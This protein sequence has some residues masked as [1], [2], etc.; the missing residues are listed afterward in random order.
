MDFQF[1]ANAPWLDFIDTELGE[2]ATRVDLIGSF[3]DLLRWA[4][5]AG[6]L[7]PAERAALDK[8]PPAGRAA[9][10]KTALQLRSDLRRAAAR[11]VEGGAPS[12]GLV[13]QVNTLMQQ[14]PGLQRLTG[15]AG[16]WRLE[17]QT[18]SADAGLVAARIAED[19]A[20]FMVTA[21]PALLRGCEGA[22]CSLYFYDTSKNHKRRW[23]SMESCGNRSKAAEFRARRS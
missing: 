7:K 10:L 2:N 11:L 18:A 14:H 4:A 9:A 1:L 5:E 8:L 3:D 22:G 15:R 13:E 16:R 6:L 12:A 21:D 19:F 20:G 23:C 17:R